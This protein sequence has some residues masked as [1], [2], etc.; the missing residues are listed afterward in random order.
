MQAA[1]NKQ[2][3]AKFDEANI[4]W[5]E[6]RGQCAH[7]VGKNGLDKLVSAGVFMS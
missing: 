1:L 6:R 4:I 2:R 7:L 5:K 3:A